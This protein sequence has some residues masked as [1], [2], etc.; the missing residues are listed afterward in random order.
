MRYARRFSLRSQWRAGVPPLC[1]AVALG[2]HGEVGSTD[3]TMETPICDSADPTQVIAPQRV[4]LLTSTQLLNMVKLVSPEEATAV[5]TNAIFDVTSEF[6]ARFPPATSEQFRSIPDSTTLTYF[7][8]L[9][10]YYDA[11][12]NVAEQRAELES[13]VGVP[14]DLPASNPER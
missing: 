11:L 14:L 6:R 2:C 5:T 7:D 10:S 1:A 3:F 4:A 8:T 12:G 9:A 13:A